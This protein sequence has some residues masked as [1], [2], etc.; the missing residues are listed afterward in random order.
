MA[1]EDIWVAGVGGRLL[2]APHRV[3]VR[4]RAAMGGAICVCAFFSLYSLP[5]GRTVL[6]LNPKTMWDPA[7]VRKKKK[8]FYMRDN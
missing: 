8:C 6:P 4:L 7:V 3:G 1:E 2:R 5:P